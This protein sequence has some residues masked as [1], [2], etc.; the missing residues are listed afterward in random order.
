MPL[1]FFCDVTESVELEVNN[2]FFSLIFSLAVDASLSMEAG[3][4]LV[5]GESPWIS[6]E[7]PWLKADSRYMRAQADISEKFVGAVRFLGEALCIS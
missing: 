4:E 6:G 3:E 1:T 2:L 5:A 7:Y